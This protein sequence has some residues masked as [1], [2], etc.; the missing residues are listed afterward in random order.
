V[1]QPW[2]LKPAERAAIGLSA[3]AYPEPI[4]DLKA[5]REAALDAYQRMRGR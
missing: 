2:T 1:H 3:G 5:S 4:V